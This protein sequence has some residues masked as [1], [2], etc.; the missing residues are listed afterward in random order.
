MNAVA[1][2]PRASETTFRCTPAPSSDV[3]AG[4]AMLTAKAEGNYRKLDAAFDDEDED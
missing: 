4:E 1:E 2:W 3:L